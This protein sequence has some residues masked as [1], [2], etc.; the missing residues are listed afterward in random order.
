MGV[1]I[2]HRVEGDGCVHA[3]HT[4]WRVMGVFI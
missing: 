2:S 1:F 4:G 3:S